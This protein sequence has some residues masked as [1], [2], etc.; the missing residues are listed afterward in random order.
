MLTYSVWSVFI[1]C[2]IRYEGFQAAI[3]IFNCLLSWLVTLRA[4]ALQIKKFDSRHLIV[5]SSPATPIFR[6]I[7]ELILLPHLQQLL[8]RSLL[9]VFELIHILVI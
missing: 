4:I 8:K 9:I 2:F 1:R 5:S 7:Y 6:V 3:F